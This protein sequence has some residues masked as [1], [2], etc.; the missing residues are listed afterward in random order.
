MMEDV[1]KWQREIRE[2]YRGAFVDETRKEISS[3][4]GVFPESVRDD[5]RFTQYR[6]DEGSIDEEFT[7]GEGVFERG[8]TGAETSLGIER[9]EPTGSRH[10]S[11]EAAREF[12]ES[13]HLLSG[14]VA[15]FEPTEHGRPIASDDEEKD[16]DP[17]EETDD[18]VAE[19]MWTV[20]LV[21]QR[22]ETLRSS[23]AGSI[24]SK[25]KSVFGWVKNTLSSISSR[26]WSLVSSH[27]SLREWSVT[28]GAGVSMFGL[29]GNADLSL[30]F[31]T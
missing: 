20:Q 29:Q 16:G 14:A 22:F 4:V 24:S 23:F 7:L 12:V 11:W 18:P 15:V 13:L 9:S 21:D 17:V 3:I 8:E 2:E 30:T 1:N 19:V 25:I 5:T 31:D 27:T 28:G 26:L 6:T 10:E